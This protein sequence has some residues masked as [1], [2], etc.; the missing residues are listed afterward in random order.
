MTIGF[1]NTDNEPL[2]PIFGKS[3]QNRLTPQSDGNFS[4]PKRGGSAKEFNATQ[5]FLKTW[6]DITKKAESTHSIPSTPL[7][8][9]DQRRQLHEDNQQTSNDHFHR[10]AN[11]EPHNVRS[12]RPPIVGFNSTSNTN[13]SPGSQSKSERDAQKRRAQADQNTTKMFNAKKNT[14]HERGGSPLSQ[15]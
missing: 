11:R 8:S 6:D 7:N 14:I 2:T 12:T 15:F 4:S 10:I 1:S 13:R 3:E 9:P 5:E